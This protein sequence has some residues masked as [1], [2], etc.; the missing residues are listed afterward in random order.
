[1]VLSWLPALGSWHSQE[2]SRGA[3]L[4]ACARPVVTSS[5][6]SSCPLLTLGCSTQ[7]GRGSRREPTV[8]FSSELAS[9]PSIKLRGRLLTTQQLGLGLALHHLLLTIRVDIHSAELAL[10][11]LTRV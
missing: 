8:V 5:S 11:A 6:S 2:L 9:H 10:E 3:L 4:A 1:M 7:A